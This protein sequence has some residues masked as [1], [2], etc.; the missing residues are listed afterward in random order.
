MAP[1]QRANSVIVTATPGTVRGMG[2]PAR[3]AFAA[4][5]LLSFGFAGAA[6][7]NSE[8]GPLTVDDL[9]GDFD[10]D[11]VEA[12]SG[13]LAAAGIEVRVRPR[14]DAMLD[15][16]APTPVQLLRLQVR[17]LALEANAGG[18]ALGAELD[19][20]MTAAGGEP[21]SALIAGWAQTASTPAA[22]TAAALLGDM[23]GTDPRRLMIPGL[24]VALF[25]SDLVGPGEVEASAS[26]TTN[27]LA[28]GPWIGAGE[29][30]FCADVTAFLT[31]ALAGINAADVELEPRWLG[32]AIERAAAFEP[33]VQRLRNSVA[34]M[35]LYVYATSIS[36]P[37]VPLLVVNPLGGFHH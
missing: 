20:V 37:W 6:C 15:V 30:D 5:T 11:T 8:D 33:D 10:G 28:L 18:G 14:D 25:L 9:R 35:S 26:S 17:N 29:P 3:R 13:L 21:V 1:V 32:D 27:G 2:G 31:A 12:A 19:A 7:S 23:N 4:V 22:E 24:V 16:D 34:A 36:R